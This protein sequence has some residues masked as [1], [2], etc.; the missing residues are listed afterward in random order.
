MRGT[1]GHVIQTISSGRALPK[2]G[3]ERFS[4]HV[5]V[6]MNG[7]ACNK[8]DSWW[9]GTPDNWRSMLLNRK[10]GWNERRGFFN[11]AFQV[12]EHVS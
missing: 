4:M 5:V 10:R 12:V 2:S 6:G 3:D 8:S 11:E 9:R 7:G 1:A